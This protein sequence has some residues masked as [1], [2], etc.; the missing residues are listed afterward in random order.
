MS[1]LF[2]PRDPSHVRVWSFEMWLSVMTWV[3]AR[4]HRG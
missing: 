1:V 3:A 2:D 4:R